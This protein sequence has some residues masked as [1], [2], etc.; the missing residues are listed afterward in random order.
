MTSI[1]KP[2]VR[3]PA[4]AVNALGLTRRDYEG[5]M[6]TLCAGCGHD[7]VTAALVQA[8][9]ELDL[10]PH[11]AAKMSGIG[12]SSKTTAYFMKQSHGFNGVH[13]RMP[14]LA[15]GAHAANRGLTMIGVSGD[16]DS[17]S[18]G[19][20]QLSHAIRRNVDMLYVLEN[21]GV[22]GL[23]KG[24]FS[25]SADIGS[26]SKRGEANV[27]PPID[28]VLLALTLGATFVARSFSGDKAQLVPILKA[29]LTHRGFALV[30]IVS[31]CVSFNDHEGSTKSYRWTRERATEVAPMDFVPLRR[32]IDAG[33]DGA[34]AGLTSVTMHDGSVVR[35][36]KVAADYDPTNREAAYAYVRERH[37]NGEVVTGLLY[38]AQGAPA[39]HEVLGTTDT[40]LVE[41]PYE[42][43][44]PGAG[45]LAELMAEY[46]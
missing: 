28:P 5:A 10:P 34:E 43:L 17:L 36:R 1:Q 29:G 4:L 15:S 11:R 38:I 8:F 42:A 45:A 7:S 20:G 21:N 25:A 46:R 2:P 39:M 31:P 19:L 32:E 40:P 18:I 3:H 27:Q 23:T 13:G 41:L 14:A 30:D 22:Y 44:C 26:K 33:L 37:R 35:F 9:W 6:S 16:G 12:C 24:Q